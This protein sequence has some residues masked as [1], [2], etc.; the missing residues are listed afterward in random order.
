MNTQAIA[1]VANFL[2]VSPNQIKRCEEWASVL[3][4]IVHG[5]KPR[6]VSKKVVVMNQVGEYQLGE[7]LE[8]REDKVY[9]KDCGRWEYVS[10]IEKGAKIRHSSRCDANEQPS[11]PTPKPVKRNELEAIGA[12]VRAGYNVDPDKIFEAYSAGYLSMSDAMNTDF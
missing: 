5:R 10:K 2:S 7:S 8:V 1:Q 9:C 12:Q 3:F 6:F 4:V 11:K